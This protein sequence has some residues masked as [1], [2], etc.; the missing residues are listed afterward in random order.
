[1]VI[2][3]DFYY[4]DLSHL[5]MEERYTVNFDHPEAFDHALLVEHLKQLKDGQPIEVPVYDYA[6]HNRS[7]E[8]VH[9]HNNKAIVVVE[10]ILLF[11]DPELREQMDIRIFVDTPLDTCFIR[12]L[13]RDVIERERSMESVISQYRK[14]VRPMFI[15]FVEPSKRYADVIIP[16]GGQNEVAM[17]M[18]V[19]RLE[20]LL[21]RE[22][23]LPTKS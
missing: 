15:Q 11:A 5:T 12:R 16:E 13:Q 20:T 2:R 19:A 9:I 21:A 17:D 23:P 6:I 7:Q 1:M 10:G 8:T 14:T 22:M 4:K 18:L 3:E